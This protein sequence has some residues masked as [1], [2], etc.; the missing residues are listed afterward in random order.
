[1]GVSGTLDYPAVG[2]DRRNLSFYRNAAGGGVGGVDSRREDSNGRVDGIAV[3]TSRGRRGC[4]GRTSCGGGRATFVAA[5]ASY[6]LA[7]GE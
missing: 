7:Q 4:G 3:N 1:M 2:N 5:R 6:M